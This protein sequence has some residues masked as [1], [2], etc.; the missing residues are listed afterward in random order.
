MQD[1]NKLRL[2]MKDGHRRSYHRSLTFTHYL[3]CKVVFHHVVLEW[4]TC[5]AIDSLVSDTSMALVSSIVSESINYFSSVT[6]RKMIER[7]IQAMSLRIFFDRKSAVEK[8]SFCPMGP[9]HPSPTLLRALLMMIGA[10][11]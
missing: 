6:V 3:C 10:R 4:R 2:Q 5:D 9:R 8:K 11:T 7:I 1:Q